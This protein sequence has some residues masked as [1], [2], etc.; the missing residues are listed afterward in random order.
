MKNVKNPIDYVQIDHEKLRLDAMEWGANTV[1]LKNLRRLTP[2]VFRSDKDSSWHIGYEK[3]LVQNEA[4]PENASYCLDRA[5]SILIR[6]QQHM[7][8]QRWPLPEW[9]LLPQTN[10]LAAPVFEQ[11]TQQSTVVHRVQSDYEYK[12]WKVVTGFN[13]DEQFWII[14]GSKPDPQNIIASG[15]IFGYLLVP[16]E[17]AG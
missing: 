8:A 12:I 13:P 4:T 11:A 16:E 7:R 10:F 17:G 1:E 5:I 2:D 6:K 15:L 14:I 9:Q 3:A